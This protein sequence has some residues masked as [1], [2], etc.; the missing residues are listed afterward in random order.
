MNL[1]EWLG[2]GLFVVAMGVA[3]YGARAEDPPSGP[4]SEKLR[5]EVIEQMRAM[6]MWKMTEEL[7]LDEAT[8]ARLF[9]LLGKFD[10]RMRDLFRER[11][12]MFR[13]LH[14]ETKSATP[15][16]KKIASLLDRMEASRT[17]RAQA[18]DERWRSMRK[19][20]TPLQ[21]AKMMLLLPRLEEGFRHRIREAL[22]KTPGEPGS[23]DSEKRRMRFG[24]EA[25]PS[26]K[27]R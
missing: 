1:R 8:A 12:A 19:V 27:G 18:E 26:F 21:Q 23:P 3:P 20:L 6:R 11:G 10:D 16:A 9:P 7:K 24:F 14:E 13:E 4:P 25:D 5:S 17:Q 15:D 22:G 2:A